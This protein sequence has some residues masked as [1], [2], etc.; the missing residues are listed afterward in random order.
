M[1]C[2]RCGKDNTENN[3]K[4]LF[5]G[6]SQKRVEP[7]TDTGKAL[8]KIFDDFGAEKVFGDSR[9]ITAAISDFIPD[10]DVLCLSI[11]L[12][13]RVGIG[14]IY[15]NQLQNHG[16]ANE[17]FYKRVEKVIIE[18][19]G[20]SESKATQLIH[21]FDEM[22]GWKNSQETT[23]GTVPDHKAE[24][25]VQTET[26]SETVSEADEQSEFYEPKQIRSMTYEEALK[27]K[28][29]LSPL[30]YS[31]SGI[32]DA[33]VAE[34]AVSD[35]A[36]TEPEIPKT[37]DA[38]SETVKASD[39]EPALKT[40][41]LRKRLRPV[42]VVG[43]ISV[44][45]ILIAMFTGNTNKLVYLT[46]FYLAALTFIG[47]KWYGSRKFNEEF[48]S[49]GQMNNQMGLLVICLFLHHAALKFEDIYTVSGIDPFVN[50]GYLI[51]AV[52]FFFA[53]LCLYRNYVANN[54]SFKGFFLQSIMPI[55]L[56]TVISGWLFI[57]VRLVA[58]EKMDLFTILNYFISSKLANVYAWYPIIIV[59]F[60]IVFYLCFR[61][62]ENK[63][64]ALVKLIAIVFIYTLIGTGLRHY[65]WWLEGEWWYNAVHMF[66]IGIVFARHEKNITDHLK[67]YYII[68]M[69]IGIVMLPFVAW[70]T[71][72]CI[73]NFSYY[74]VDRWGIRY[75]ERNQLYASDY[76]SQ[77]FLP[78]VGKRWITLL[79][80]MLC[81]LVF[82]L[83]FIMVNLKVKIGNTALSFMG[84]IALE[85][86][87]I[88]GL[89]V[90]VFSNFAF[91][92]YSYDS[93]F[94]LTRISYSPLYYIGSVPIF[95]LEVLLLG[96][97]GAILLKLITK[98][99]LKLFGCN[100]TKS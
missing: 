41:S 56:V 97:G 62:T 30:T 94:S 13:Y 48:L 78:M 9:I 39:A 14:T 19:A 28:G 26:V 2:W 86:F 60:Y 4:C 83:M 55:S 16:A 98:P 87:L 20:L 84:K 88:H 37:S 67:R 64:L 63:K 82:A 99:V 51:Y 5:C 33:S 96:I 17:E 6:T 53:G 81:S 38:K 23:A 3:E 100:K 79:S 70:L 36:G 25:N 93:S 47:S 29:L 85:F 44:V 11:E 95:E 7:V 80:Q 43:E 46:Y 92:T 15:N 18:D 24:Q 50:M 12:V 34:K 22:I 69:L 21:L 65:N 89:F 42:I 52:F 71:W 68:Y 90:E 74:P 58:G 91:E 8:R 59:L 61:F 32:T 27:E 57:P 31:E 49:D 72:F 75:E 77:Y 45:L 66:W 10:S 76:I 40:K 73:K 35:S 1:K 54:G